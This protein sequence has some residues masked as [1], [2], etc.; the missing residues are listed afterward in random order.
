VLGL[1]GDGGAQK[2][3]GGFGLLVGQHAE[4]ATR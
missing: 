4:K 1:E 2:G 3:D